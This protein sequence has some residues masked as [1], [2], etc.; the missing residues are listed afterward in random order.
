MAD[1]ASLSVKLGLVTLEWDNKVE[2]AK[3][4]AQDLQN[5]FNRLGG[6]VKVLADH[7]RQF[8]GII[9]AV[10]FAT[11]IQQTFEFTDQ[12]TDLAKAFDITTSETLHFRD[13]LVSAGSKALSGSFVNNRDVY[14][15]G[16]K[17]ISGIDYSGVGQTV[18]ISTTNLIDGDI[19]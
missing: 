6:G 18:V 9:G 13:A 14:L 2:G 8:G 15:N 3:K 16:N 11:I 10:S 5:A 12:I 19:I 7:W 4:Q 1:I 17:L